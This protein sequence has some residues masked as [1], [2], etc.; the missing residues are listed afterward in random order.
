[1]SGRSVNTVL[2]MDELKIQVRRKP[3]K[4]LYLRITREDLQIVVSAPLWM[5]PEHIEAFVS[6]KKAWLKEKM[7]LLRQRRD[8]C[9]NQ[10]E[11]EK[12]WLWGRP[13]KIKFV[14]GKKEN[15]IGEEEIVFVRRYALTAAEQRKCV[16]TF[17]RQQLK[18]RLSILADLWEQKLGMRASEWCIR[19]MTSRWG[20]CNIRSRRITINYNLL[21]WPPECLELVVVH[22]LAHLY[23][24]S[25]NK[26]FKNFVAYY[27]PDWQQRDQLLKKFVFA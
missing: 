15:L 20:S 3:I 7:F 18:Q 19:K 8:I 16:E 23:E 2:Q 11:P 25:H 27:L 26:R 9:Q 21:H 12:L 10:N 6:S 4:G 13:Y 14:A 24:A 22:E 17:S 5:A 1:M